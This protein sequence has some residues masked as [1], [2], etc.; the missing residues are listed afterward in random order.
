MLAAFHAEVR[1]GSLKLRLNVTVSLYVFIPSTILVVIL[2]D[3]VP[4]YKVSE[5]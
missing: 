4:A 3:F 5:V 2:I 1:H